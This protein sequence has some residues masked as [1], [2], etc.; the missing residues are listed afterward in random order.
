MASAGNGDVIVGAMKGRGKGWGW[1]EGRAWFAIEGSAQL[2]LRMSFIE[3]DARFDLFI[4]GWVIGH[5][6][7]ASEVAKDHLIRKANDK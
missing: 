5:L 3:M 4:V 1:N 6:S 7:L 2:L